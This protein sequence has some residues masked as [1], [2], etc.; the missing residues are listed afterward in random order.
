MSY[1]QLF[2]E[3]FDAEV[4][5]M[6]TSHSKLSRKQKTV[7]GVLVDD[8]EFDTVDLSNDPRNDL[9]YQD[10]CLG[11]LQALGQLSNLKEVM[12]QRDDVD[13]VIN[14]I[15]SLKSASDESVQTP[16]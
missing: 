4:S 10:F 8:F 11:N 12:L 5:P 7:N 6:I 14:S 16:Q 1:L 13:V 2:K 3:N 9:R 15:E